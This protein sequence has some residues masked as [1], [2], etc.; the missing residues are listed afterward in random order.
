MKGE[1]LMKKICNVCIAVVVAVA[2]KGD[3][4]DDAIVWLRGDS[5]LNDDG[6]IQVGEIV[7]ALSPVATEAIK[8][9]GWLDGTVSGQP[10]DFVWTNDVIVCPYTMRTNLNAKC[11]CFRQNQRS[12]DN[13]LL[14][15]TISMDSS[16]TSKITSNEWAFHI[17]FKWH[18]R[19]ASSYATE[20][21]ILYVGNSASADEGH[22]FRLST[23]TGGELTCAI[24]EKYFMTYNTMRTTISSNVWVDCVF[25]MTSTNM[26]E[27]SVMEEG[28]ILKTGQC[29]PGDLKFRPN[30]NGS[31]VIGN[32][33]IRTTWE[34]YTGALSFNAF[35]GEVAEFALWN[36]SLSPED[37]L[38]VMAWPNEDLFRA[39]I[40]NGTSAEFDGEGN[41]SE[42]AL[43]PDCG[44][45]AFGG[46]IVAGASKSISFM[47]PVRYNGLPQVLRYR[48]A[49]GSAS[50]RLAV[51][52]DGNSVG[53]IDVIPGTWSRLQIPALYFSG[54]SISTLSISR[55]D[56]GASPIKTDAV[57]L[58]GSW[59]EGKIS[60]NQWEN[61]DN[62]A[63]EPYY[64]PDGNFKHF[65]ATIKANRR[66]TVRFDVPPEIAGNYNFKANYKM[67][68]EKSGTLSG[69]D[70]VVVAYVNG[71][72]LYEEIPK[73]K[74]WWPREFNI[75]ARC[76]LPG[77]N[78]I[79]FANEGTGDSTCYVSFD[80]LQLLVDKPVRGSM[81]II[82]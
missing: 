39:G 37:R 44:W 45:G 61:D 74:A 58:G 30:P 32:S 79:A 80:Y 18:G 54:D 17:R 5:D 7:D 28:G 72:R 41:V 23:T 24:G 6:R 69:D 9:N 22:G 1:V 43:S 55:A 21:K 35:V 56:G 68:F 25:S 12:S 29:K 27:W 13:A 64:V 46:D 76:I 71:N 40:A 62:S 26:V 70:I 49:P 8:P 51:T 78:T 34:A 60:G 82:Y 31:V 42:A 15:N 75:P 59:Q 66:Q 33:G 77:E 50:G 10:G 3:I 48:A 20:N 67:L 36:R 14:P 4:H 19:K 63:M 73:S 52:M 38:R 57:A 16:W 47:V 81:L 53:S 11:Y 2:A 65:R